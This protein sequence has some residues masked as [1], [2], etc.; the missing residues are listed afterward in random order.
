MLPEANFLLSHLAHLVKT[1]LAWALVIG[2]LAFVA[3]G[4]WVN[5][6]GK[7]R[8]ELIMTSEDEYQEY[9]QSEQ[10]VTIRNKVYKDSDGLCVICQSPAEA[11]HH[12]YYPDNLEDDT[13]AGKMAVC[14]RCHKAIH[15]I[16]PNILLRQ[17]IA[18][19]IVSAIADLEPGGQMKCFDKLVSLYYRGLV[20]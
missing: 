14:T 4:V 9:L 16:Q 1:V 17:R 2:L 11:I 13:T 18:Y 8:G 15:G 3:G 19:A 10:W 12:R 6:W 20:D 5:L 7:K